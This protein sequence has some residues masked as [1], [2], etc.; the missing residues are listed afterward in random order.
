M[1]LLRG[2]SPACNT[3]ILIKLSRLVDI[4]LK[5]CGTPAFDAMINRFRFMK[6]SFFSKFNRVKSLWENTWRISIF[7]WSPLGIFK[8]NDFFFFFYIKNHFLRGIGLI[9][10]FGSELL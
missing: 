7:Q 9:N 8:K 2:N 6:K 10:A 1:N 4:P 5:H 3:S